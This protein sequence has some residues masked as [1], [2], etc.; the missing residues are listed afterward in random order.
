[1]DIAVPRTRNILLLA[2]L[3]VVFLGLGTSYLTWQ[4]VNRQRVLV[5]EQMAHSGQA[6]FRGIESAIVREMRGEIL[7]QLRAMRVVREPE[8]LEQF[9]EKT[10]SLL[11]EIV[12]DK[13]VDF[14]AVY[15][16][17]GNR[18]LFSGDDGEPEGFEVPER[19]WQ[20]VETIGVWVALQKYAGRDVLVLL[21]KSRPPLAAFAGPVQ[22]RGRHG[23]HMDGMQGDH[24]QGMQGMHGRSAAA[25]PYLMLGMNVQQYMKKYSDFE[26]NAYL[27]T[28]YVSL[29]ALVLWMLV[30]A[31]MRRRE[32]GLAYDK[33]ERFHSRLL[34]TMP[35]GLVAVDA[36]GDV[37]AANPA[38]VKLLLKGDDDL[39]GKS[40]RDLG[41]SKGEPKPG[42][43][44]REGIERG[45]FTLG[46]RTLEIISRPIPG[47]DWESETQRLILVRDRTEVQ[48]LEK[49]LAQAEKLAAVGR[50]A[51][52]L[53]H[54]IRN[55]LSA[56][57][58]FA[59]YFQERFKGKGEEED[60][61]RIMVSEADRLNRV[62]TDL[63]YLA[64]PR[65][66][67]R[68]TVDVSSLVTETTRLLELDIEKK[69]AQVHNELEVHELR[70]DPDQV[71]QALL[72]L[73][74][75]SL[76][77]VPE[78]TGQITMFS[79]SVNGAVLL[80]V[81]DNGRGM[82]EDELESAMEPFFTGRADGTGLGL[83]VVHKIMRDHGGR[84]EIDSE[85]GKGATVTLVFPEQPERD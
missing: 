33:L 60:Y 77:A 50:L 84:V 19:A 59:Q 74:L 61:A 83:S 29:V 63:L 68:R 67:T 55:P 35:D 17:D 14:L 47:A 3:A 30:L 36:K 12:T 8:M 76:E 65:P 28:A 16:Q 52:G 62:V 5:R 81:A 43:T 23:K 58:G 37:R 44:E 9:R 72:N 80:G 15:S 20:S 21:A 57:R 41:L 10:Q 56:L 24:M 71:K 31:Y 49:E 45:Q 18:L 75:N 4:N 82:S 7:E 27:Q 11:D 40:W 53:A 2:M 78:K 38:A 1:M 70:A 34:D 26:R 79:A 46:G 32:E 13:D 48:A 6:L 66:L 51:A 64:K 85:K 22:S 54:E 39:V 73:L 42:V 69:G 25:E